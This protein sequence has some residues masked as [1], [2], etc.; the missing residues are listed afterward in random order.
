MPQG[1]K[2]G[3]MC[4]IICNNDLTSNHSGVTLHKF[5]D[6]VTITEIYQTTVGSHM[7]Q[8]FDNI[9]QW[10]NNNKM[11]INPVKTKLC[12]LLLSRRKAKSTNGI[13]IFG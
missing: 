8:H 10:S 7:Q 9:N 1:S 12:D 4:Y 3:S 13:V 5:I 11:V 2:L 6:D